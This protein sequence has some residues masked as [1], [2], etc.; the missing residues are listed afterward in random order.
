M[1]GMG[2]PARLVFLLIACAVVLEGFDLQ[3]VGFAAPGMLA[4]WSLPKQALGLALS[5]SLL[6][7]T[8][9][10]GGGGWLGDRFGRRP[11]LIYCLAAF[12]LATLATASAQSPAPVAILRLIAGFGFGAALANAMALTAEWTVPERV[13]QIVG[14]MIIGVPVGGMTGALICSWMIPRFGWRSAFIVGGVLP[15]LLALAM[16]F[17]LKE[18][19]RFVATRQRQPDR[20]T[21]GS[22]PLRMLLSRPY[23]RATIALAAA[24]FSNLAVSY[25]FFNWIP[26]ML[27]A[28]GLSTASAI[29]GSLYFNLSG[30]IA[31][32][33]GLRLFGARGNRPFLLGYGLLGIVVNACL[34]IALYRATPHVGPPDA[35][36]LL[37][38]LSL[39]GVATEGLQ[40]GLY[41]FAASVYPTACRSS[42]IGVAGTFGR[43]GGI[44]SAY[45][46][47]T[48]LS[49]GAGASVFLVTIAMLF[50]VSVGAVLGA[51]SS[52]ECIADTVPAKPPAQ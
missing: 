6:G 28:Q 19:G 39:A 14:Y 44:L 10:S 22:Q 27:S 8:F 45:F 1:S 26:V 20:P 36:T 3:V 32:F 2:T 52:Q 35:A 21:P 30:A 31:A 46:G 51:G 12:G 11:L 41:G 29:R 18:S 13:T 9:G 47:G 16:L 4:D 49:L 37:L 7:M 38:G 48:L 33:L 42:G 15:M 23:R 40:T 24:F 25:A 17:W 43:A 5:A 34:A 50:I